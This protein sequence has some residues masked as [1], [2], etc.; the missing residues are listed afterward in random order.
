MRNV[1][2]II[3]I[4]IS[5]SLSS[6]ISGGP[7]E[8]PIQVESGVISIVFKDK[9]T[10]KYLYPV[11]SPSFYYKDSLKIYHETGDTLHLFWSPR[12]LQ[13]SAP[14]TDHFTLTAYFFDQK[15][16]LESYQ[17]EVCRK[18]YIH[19]NATERDTIQLCF[20]TRDTKCGSEFE[21]AQLYHDGKSVGNSFLNS[22]SADIFKD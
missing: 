20:K 6:C 11:N 18:Y 22:V 1:L 7:C 19:Y 12:L 5:C 17:R 13:P 14:V 8:E 9:S 3:G 2:F 4:T 10:D 16:D 21:R 15:R